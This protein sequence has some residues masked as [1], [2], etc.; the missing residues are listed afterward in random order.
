MDMM[1]MTM[2]QVRE[3]AA[4]GTPVVIPFG[5][6]EEHG[7]HLPLATDTLQAHAV[8][9]RAA[10]L[11][12]ALVAPPVHYGICNSTR[13]HPGTVTLSGDTFRSL[14]RDLIRSL[15]KQGFGCLVLFS[16]HAGRVHMSSLREAAQDCV[17][18]D[19]DLR[20][21]V[22][23]DF[24]LVIRSSGDIIDT[25]TDSHAGEIETSRMLFLHP[26]S[27]RGRSPAELPSLPPFR[28]VPDPEKYWPGGVWG[29]PGAADESKGRVMVEKSAAELA[30]V[31]R[32]LSEPEI[33]GSS[34]N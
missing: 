34:H 31:I 27:V 17:A 11:Q 30:A 33:Q 18:D 14:V 21:A 6:T 9:I 15:A 13:N 32:G 24:D 10:A 28:V 7:S 4:L 19:P 26:D 5:S 20:I 2:D 12:H 22:V 16:G 29:D 3:E 8:A 1:W 23:S 25:G